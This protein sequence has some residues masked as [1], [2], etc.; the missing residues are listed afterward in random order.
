MMSRILRKEKKGIEK[1]QAKNHCNQHSHLVFLGKQEK[2]LNDRNCLWSM[3][4][5][6]LGVVTCTQGMTIPSFLTSGMRL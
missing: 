4:K 3:T 2:I 1:M 5:H 6:A